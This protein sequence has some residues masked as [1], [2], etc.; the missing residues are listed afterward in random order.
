MPFGWT[1]KILRI[2]LTERKVRTESTLKYT[3]EF[4]AGRGIAAKILYDE[5][6]LRTCNPSVC[7]IYNRIYWTK[8][9]EF[10]IIFRKFPSKCD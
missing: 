10:V 8:V 1:G 6:T 5:Y 9:L 3:K 2:D 4:M 7:G